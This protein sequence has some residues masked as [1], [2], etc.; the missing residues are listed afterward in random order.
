[1]ADLSAGLMDSSSG[2][3][4]TKLT[5]YQALSSPIKMRLFS[6]QAIYSDLNQFPPQQYDTQCN[7]SQTVGPRSSP[8]KDVSTRDSSPDT[9]VDVLITPRAS[10]SGIR[11]PAGAR[12]F[13]LL[14]TVQTD[15]GAHPASY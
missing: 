2:V 4:A 11:I 15:S 14:Q 9:S 12:N 13:S 6:Q 1:M 7:V 5:T 3:S 8:F 10:R